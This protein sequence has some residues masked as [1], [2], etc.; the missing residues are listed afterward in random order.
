MN[1]IEKTIN[2]LNVFLEH[3][4]VLSLDDMSRLTGMNKTTVRRIAIALVKSGF[5]KQPEKRG[6]YSLGMRF[7]D[8]SKAIKANNQIMDAAA[9]YLFKLSQEVD[10]TVAL[11]LWDGES[12]VICQNIHPNHPLKVISN[13]G[14]ILGLHYTS[15]GKA[16]AAQLPESDLKRLFAGGLSRSTPNSITDFNDLKKHL[17]IAKQQG[18]AID[19]EEYALGV[20]GVSAAFKDENGNVLGAISVLGPSVRLSRERLR[21]IVISVKECAGKVSYELGYHGA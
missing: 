5:L 21:E 11:A 4:I 14:K 8:F 2:L 18:V 12:A 10:E 7:L 6:K 20:R 1:V 19:D 13:E 17:L 3:S 15:L 16:I 9:P